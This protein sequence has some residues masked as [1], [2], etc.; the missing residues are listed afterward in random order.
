MKLLKAAVT[1][2]SSLETIQVVE[3]HNS[4]TSTA[5]VEC[6]NTSLELG[7][8]IE[9]YLGYDGGAYD[10]VF[11]GH[12][13]LIEYNVNTQAYTITCAD[14]LTR[15]VDYF[16]APEDPEKPFERSNISAEALV[17]DILE[18]CGITNYDYQETYFV[19][20]INGTKVEVK[21][22]SAYDAIKS[23][24]DLI[25]WHLWADRDG[26]VHFRN[27]KPY[28]MYGNSGQ[29]GDIADVDIN[30][31]INRANL[32]VIDLKETVS[33][34]NLRNRVIVWGSN[35]V[36]AT[37]SSPSPHLPPNFYKTVLFSHPIISTAELAQKTANYNL[38]LLN[39]LT[40]SLSVT[41]EGNPSL[42]SRKT[43]YV[44]DPQINRR[45][46]IYECRHSWGPS[47]YIT[48]LEL[49]A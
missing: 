11:T 6:Y 16:F 22:I 28:I 20:G 2:C 32:D 44:S 13:K 29:P 10:K 42:Q 12:V 3:S 21:L 23:V 5:V 45:Y 26:V 4:P 41:L 34:K 31:Q 37:A 49:T 38:A 25:A 33:E 27:R 9:I 43:V 7:D 47:G 8:E 48:Q 1:G 14:I 46:Y 35:G 39:R 24:A 17:G 19:I 18:E 15:A 30:Y 40:Y 36:T